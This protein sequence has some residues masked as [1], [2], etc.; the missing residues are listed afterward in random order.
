MTNHAHNAAAPLRRILII[1]DDARLLQ[2]IALQLRLS[3]EWLLVG[4]TADPADALALTNNERPDVVLLDLWLHGVASLGLLAE[5]RA[6]TPPPL[7]ILLS[8]EADPIW[9]ERARAGGA[10]AFL[11]KHEVFDIPAALRTILER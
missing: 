8:A 5:L 10:A 2:I 1:D 7:V 6:R 3:G 11:N 9:H 4:S